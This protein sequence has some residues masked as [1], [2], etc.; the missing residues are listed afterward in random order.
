M[1]TSRIRVAALAAIVALGI[2]V[3]ALAGCGSDQSSA[4]TPR[5]AERPASSPPVRHFDLDALPGGAARKQ[6]KVA[7]GS[8][9]GT[10]ATAD[11]LQICRATRVDV[12]CLSTTSMQQVRLGAGPAVF[13]G[14]TDGAGFPYDANTLEG[15]VTTPA[16]ISCE[17]SSRGIECSRGGHGF[18][19]G[20]WAVVTLQGPSETRYESDQA[21]DPS[22]QGGP[23]LGAAEDLSDVEISD[24]SIFVN[25]QAARDAY[26]AAPE[27]FASLVDSSGVI[28]PELP[29]E[30]D[31]GT[32]YDGVDLSVEIPSPVGSDGYW[33]D[34]C[35]GGSCYGAIS[36]ANGLP[37][38]TFVEGYTRA[39][40]TE[41]GSY[42]RSSP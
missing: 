30:I 7:T 12:A 4:Q 19:I 37:R 34:T 21:P 8:F 42:Y 5:A 23:D 39:D 17:R 6:A 25:R 15:T 22:T 29:E 38:T 31:L 35:P 24:C 9:T 40:G 11:G 28:C 32:T 3:G 1:S 41:V 36:E 27:M 14:V 2:A 13:E 16:G 20:D 33:A 26:D 18:R 10:F